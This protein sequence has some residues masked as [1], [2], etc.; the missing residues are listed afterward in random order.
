M[1]VSLGFDDQGSAMMVWLSILA[2]DP[3]VF[4]QADGYAMDMTH[5]VEMTL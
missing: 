3:V 5:E 4:L 2:G 1:G